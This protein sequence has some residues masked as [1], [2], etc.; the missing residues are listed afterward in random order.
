MH[1]LSLTSNEKARNYRD[2]PKE[3]ALAESSVT[4]VSLTVHVY[5]IVKQT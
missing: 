3:A 2:F 1:G 4:L 5:G